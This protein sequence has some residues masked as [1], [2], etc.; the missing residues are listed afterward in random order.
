MKYSQSYESCDFPD[1]F[2]MF[3]WAG[4]KT[5]TEEMAKAGWLA[6]CLY[7]RYMARYTLRF[8]H[9]ELYMTFALKL[10]REELMDLDSK[11]FKIEYLGVG[12]KRNRIPKSVRMHELTPEH[13]P[14]LLRA[15]AALQEPSRK[16]Q[17]K[18][19]KLPIAEIVDFEE[20]I[21]R[22]TA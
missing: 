10:T 18:K 11:Y 5:N 7:N 2:I 19:T 12:G 14:M 20:Y 16:K 22:M 1:A 15:V 4:F 13:V 6:K 17:L 9:P 8:Y 3:E 21:E